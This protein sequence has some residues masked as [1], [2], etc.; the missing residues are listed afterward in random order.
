MMSS[1]EMREI[2]FSGKYAKGRDADKNGEW[3]F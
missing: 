2:V 1:A 3:Y